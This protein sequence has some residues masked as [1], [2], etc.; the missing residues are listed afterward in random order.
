MWSKWAADPLVHGRGGLVGLK[1]GLGLRR[2][3]LGAELTNCSLE[4]GVSQLHSG[5]LDPLRP[6]HTSQEVPPPDNF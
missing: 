3:G 2:A 5:L 1:S 6:A 4:A